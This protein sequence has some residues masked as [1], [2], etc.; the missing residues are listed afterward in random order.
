MDLCTERRI[1]EAFNILGDRWV[2]LI[3]R[4]VLNGSSQFEDLQSNLGI[5]RNILS[6]K[7]KKLVEKKLLSKAPLEQG[8]RRL[9]YQPTKK[10]LALKSMLNDIEE[11]A[12]I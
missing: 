7:L 10:C 2:L 1:I 12:L 4:E 6:M 11:W 9:V 3:L 5:S 8:R